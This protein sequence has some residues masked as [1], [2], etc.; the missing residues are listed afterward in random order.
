M[1][2]SD[3]S[4]QREAGWPVRVYCGRAGERGQCLKTRHES[5]NGELVLLEEEIVGPTLKLGGA[6]GWGVDWGVK[7]SGMT[8]RSIKW[9]VFEGSNAR[10]LIYGNDFSSKNKTIMSTPN[11]TIKTFLQIANILTLVEVITKEW[12]LFNYFMSPF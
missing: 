7:K 9:K 3:L 2:Q 10:R 6:G 12:I 5:G 1:W 4:G 8:S 11:K